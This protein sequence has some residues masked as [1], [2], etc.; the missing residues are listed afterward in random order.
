MEDLFADTIYVFS[1]PEVV[2]G[3]LPVRCQVIGLTDDHGAL[4]L[5]WC[6]VE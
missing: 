6:G 3:R 5:V 1:L 2:V 4:V